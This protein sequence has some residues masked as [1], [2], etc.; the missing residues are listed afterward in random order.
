MSRTDDIYKPALSGK[1][2]PILTL[3]HK[4]HQLFTQTDCTKRIEEL[5]HKLNGLLKRQGKLQTQ[6]KEIKKLK[7]R[8]MEEIMSKMEVIEGDLGDNLN[9]K[10]DDNKRLINECNDK[11]QETQ[12]A[13]MELPKE[14]AQVNHELML[15]TMGVCYDRI[16][17]SSTEIEEI[18][19]WITSVR[20]ELKKKVIQK[21][22]MEVM[23]QE[24][25]N[26]MHDIFGA[27]VINIF[28]MKYI[29]KKQE[30]TLEITKTEKKTD[31]KDGTTIIKEEIIQEEKLMKGQIQEEKLRED[32]LLNQSRPDD[33]EESL[34]GQNGNGVTDK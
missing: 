15:E 1:N 26:Y 23:N 22:E 27:D 8:L 19:K 33:K 6:K 30:A 3:D 29:G 11:I 5:E 21:Q 9:K 34:P 20:I 2:I 17:K 10:L 14:I 7:A 32:M 24:L 13:L 31:E 12:D 4:W 18:S 28:D 25:Y 16:Q